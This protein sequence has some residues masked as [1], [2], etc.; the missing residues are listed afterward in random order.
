MSLHGWVSRSIIGCV[1]TTSHEQMHKRIQTLKMLP[2]GYNHCKPL[3]IG[4]YRSAIDLEPHLTLGTAK[5]CGNLGGNLGNNLN[6]LL[7][8]FLQEKVEQKCMTMFI[9][10][11]QTH[12]DLTWWK[13]FQ[14]HRPY[15][16]IRGQGK[17]K[18]YLYTCER[19]WS[20]AKPRLSCCNL[21]CHPSFGHLS[22]S[23]GLSLDSLTS[24][25]AWI[26]SQ[27]PAREHWTVPAAD[28]AMPGQAINNL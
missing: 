1:L 14:N 4:P 5:S 8:P 24:E 6:Q 27:I 7:E 19:N 26:N 2:A 21:L 28:H 11:L 23:L 16:V 9:F 17:N 25:V 13:D 18:A 3:Q 20:T 15:Q 12:L 22:A 10:M